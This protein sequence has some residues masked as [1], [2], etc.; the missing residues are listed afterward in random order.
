MVSL[1]GAVH[2]L[3]MLGEGAFKNVDTDIRPFI[4][5]LEGQ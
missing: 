1:M 3:R 5:Q 4:T 2:V